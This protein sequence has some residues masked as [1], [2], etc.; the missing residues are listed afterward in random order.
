[1]RGEFE[2]LWF[3]YLQGREHQDR[4]FQAY[5]GVVLKL[6]LRPKGLLS[7]RK[8]TRMKVYGTYD[9]YPLSSDMQRTSKNKAHISLE[10]VRRKGP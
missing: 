10:G 8:L 3:S 5:L 9:Q 2:G 4:G 1:M 7:Q 6:F